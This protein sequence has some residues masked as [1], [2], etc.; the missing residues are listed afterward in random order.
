MAIRV[1]GVDDYVDLDV[2]IDDL[3]PLTTGTISVWSKVAADDGTQEAVFTISNNNTG[4]PTEERRVEIIIFYD[5]RDG[6]DDNRPDKLNVW[7]R[8][9][10]NLQWGWASDANFLDAFIGK[11]INIV[12]THNGT[13]PTIYCNGD[14]CPG[15]LYDTTNDHFW[16]AAVLNA[17][18][19]PDADS[20]DIGIF[21]L[22]GT[23]VIPF[24]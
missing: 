24:T 17:V 20:I 6:D 11:Y 18:S 15:T 23:L 4:T 13:V 9:N 5:M 19:G 10:A 2:L 7:C 22:N 8:V 3:K 21:K 14:V 1:D 12:V 16:F